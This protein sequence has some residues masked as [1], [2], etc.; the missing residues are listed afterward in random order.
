MAGRHG[1][2]VGLLAEPLDDHVGR[3]RYAVDERGSDLAGAQLRELDVRPQLA[4][5]DAHRRPLAAQAAQR[6]GQDP[7]G[8]GRAHEA[9]RELPGGAAAERSGV[10]DQR[11]AARDDLAGRGE[12][13]APCRGQP[14]PAPVAREQCHAEEIF[15]LA[16]LPAER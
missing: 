1:Q 13:P 14:D 7:A 8:Q 16:D 11:V 9:D 10:V 12:Q 6:R 15:E 2:H 4:Q 5:R 3:A